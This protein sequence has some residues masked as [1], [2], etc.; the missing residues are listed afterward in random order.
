[1]TY[2]KLGSDEQRRGSEQ[3]KLLFRQMLFHGLLPRGLC[4]EKVHQLHRQ[5]QS[6]V[7]QLEALLDLHHPVHEERSH[8][9]RYSLHPGEV[10]VDGEQTLQ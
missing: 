8:P 7:V 10:V 5:V 4:Q 1:M 9:L 2:I 6:L 3:L